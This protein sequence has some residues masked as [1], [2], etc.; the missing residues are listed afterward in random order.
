MGNNLGAIQ[1]YYRN[2]GSLNKV[3]TLPPHLPISLDF[4]IYLPHHWTGS[5]GSCRTLVCINL[6]RL[7]PRQVLWQMHNN[8]NPHWVPLPLL[9]AW[10]SWQTT[11]GICSS[12]VGQTSRKQLQ[13]WP[14]Q[15]KF[16]YRIPFPVQCILHFWMGKD[17]LPWLPRCVKGRY[18]LPQN[19]SS[20]RKLYFPTS[21]IIPSTGPSQTGTL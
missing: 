11:A 5:R 9:A 8:V 10:G 14:M 6:V 2:P 18:L 4:I 7:S 1:A 19:L 15:K 17:L 20:R 21:F 12:L 13:D 16:L 3:S